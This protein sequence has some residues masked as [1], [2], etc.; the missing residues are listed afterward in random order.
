MTDE[1][2]FPICSVKIRE[3][4]IPKNSF[5]KFLWTISAIFWNV[6]MSESIFE[7]KYFYLM[8]KATFYS[9]KRLLRTTRAKAMN[10]IFELRQLE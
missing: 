3:I 5:K 4:E 8:S 10:F 1:V 2:I 6:M 7:A 9:N